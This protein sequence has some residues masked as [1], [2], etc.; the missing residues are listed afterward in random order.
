MLRNQQ[1]LSEPQKLR[2]ESLS[3]WQIG[4]KTSQDSQAHRPTESYVNQAVASCPRHTV[5]GAHVP[6][7]LRPVVS[8]R[9]KE[10]VKGL[11]PMPAGPRR[12]GVPSCTYLQD[13]EPSTARKM[14]RDGLASHSWGTGS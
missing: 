4:L 11:G 10:E 12:K 6:S 8:L 14:L 1:S 3:V 13:A 7:R 9:S 2:L 5:L